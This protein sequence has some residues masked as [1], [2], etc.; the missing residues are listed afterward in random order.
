MD[1]APLVAAAV[2]CAAF[3]STNLD[4]LL[5]LAAFRAS[6][7]GTR[8]V[9]VG[10]WTALLAIVALAAGIGLADGAFPAWPMGWLGLIPIIL[11]LAQ[12]GLLLKGPGPGMQHPRPA[13]STTTAAAVFMAMS[14]DSVAI[15]GPLTADTADRLEVVVL[16]CWIAMGGVWTWASGW[17][18]GRP[19]VARVAERLGAWISPLIMVLVGTYI[20]LDTSTD[21]LPG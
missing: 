5:A 21:A 11:G 18:A 12:L 15:L 9:I 20:L 3:V 13:A 1:S 19:A 4:N 10:Y 8:Q 14:V 2:T 16:A 7:T 17:L 6:G